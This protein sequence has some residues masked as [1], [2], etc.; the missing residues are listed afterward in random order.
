[1]TE[2]CIGVLF[3]SVSVRFTPPSP[4]CMRVNLK[5]KYSSKFPFFLID[6]SDADIVLKYKWHVDSRGYIGNKKVGRLH[7]LLLGMKAGLVIDHMNRNRWD[8]RRSNLRHTTPSVNSANRVASGVYFD[9]SRAKWFA[10]IRVN[11]VKKNLGRF[12]HKKDAL[13]AREAAMCLYF[14]L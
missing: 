4:S 2:I 12:L 8:N 7:Q 14:A 9:K 5:G 13:A 6:D 11:Y 3:N 10:H 1:M